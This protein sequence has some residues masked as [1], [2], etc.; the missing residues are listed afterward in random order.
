MFGDA[1]WPMDRTAELQGPCLLAHAFNLPAFMLVA[2][3][4]PT[5][6]LIAIA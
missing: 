2:L 5:F 3:F 4:S 6:E 1:S